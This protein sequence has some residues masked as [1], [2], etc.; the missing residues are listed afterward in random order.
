[1]IINQQVFATQL[2]FKEKEMKKINFI[3]IFILTLISISNAWEVN[4]HRAIDKEAIDGEGGNNLK[5][6]VKDA[7]L[8]DI[9]YSK[10]IFSS[11]LS[12]SCGMHIRL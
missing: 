11:F 2:N 10:Q 8:K 1:M 3:F 6:F 4:T 5:I 9:D 7:D 12:S